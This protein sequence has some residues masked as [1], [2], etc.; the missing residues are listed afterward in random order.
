MNV[1]VCNHIVCVDEVNVHVVR[2]IKM[3]FLGSSKFVKNVVFGS[4]LRPLKIAPEGAQK[5]QF[6]A[7]LGG[8]PKIWNEPIS[9][10]FCQKRRFWLLTV[11]H[12]SEPKKGVF[13]GVF[14]GFWGFLRGPQGGPKNDQKTTIFGPFLTFVK[15]RFFV[16]ITL[17]NVV[18]VVI[19]LL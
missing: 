17:T 13:L 19:T 10:I 4:F 9:D 14:G 6:F 11:P 3:D 2:R 8:T 18:N 5:G 12:P 7:I 16:F 15:T 1:F